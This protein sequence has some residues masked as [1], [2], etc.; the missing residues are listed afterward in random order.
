MNFKGAGRFKRI[1]QDESTDSETGAVNQQRKRIRRM[2]SDSDDDV[3]CLDREDSAA[4]LPLNRED[5]SATQPYSL[6]SQRSDATEIY[7]LGSP[8]K[9]STLMESVV[10]TSDPDKL[11]KIEFL[12][13]CFQGKTK[14]VVFYCHTLFRIDEILIC[15]LMAKAI[16]QEH[17]LKFKEFIV[18]YLINIYY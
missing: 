8:K 13:A 7:N 14:L 6:D 17:L 4:T 15:H 10:L 12:S 18:I 9:S 3:V 1:R 11:R 16:N 2:S 5:S